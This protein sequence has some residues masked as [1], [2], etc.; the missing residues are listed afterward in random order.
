MSNIF[1]K[2]GLFRRKEDGNATIEFVLLFPAFITLFLMGF[3]S[4][5]YMVR[6]VMLERGVD[7]AIRDVRLGNGNVPQ[8]EVLRKRICDEAVMLRDC[9]N[10]LQ[11]EIQ[12]VAI[13]PGGIATMQTVARCRNKLDTS[14]N[15]LDDTTYDVGEE[16]SMMIVRVCLLQD[17]LFP[18][19][20][21]GAG[22]G[23]D[24]IG[25]YAMIATSAFV[26]EPGT[27]SF[28]AAPTTGGGSVGGSGSGGQLGDNPSTGGNY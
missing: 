27:R 7:I 1:H 18:T 11:I 26:N 28:A 3:E 22:L 9:E 5:Y 13:Q 17:P 4:G 8:F 23:V 15:A 16:N 19:T 12:E 20:G 10:S 6:N 2:A 14:A 21:I 25:N 24:N